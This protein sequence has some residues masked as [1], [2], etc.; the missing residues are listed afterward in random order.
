MYNNVI[1]DF[2]GTLVDIKTSEED[3]V[4][5]QKLSYYMA[6]QGA[7]YEPSAL[8]SS[9]EKI[10]DKHLA[11]YSGDSPELDINDVF[12]RLYM[13]KGL[14]M[15]PKQVKNTA[16]FFRAL[17]TD[18]IKVYEDVEKVLTSL[19]AKKVK[20][21]LLSNA[22]RVY[23]KAE[24]KMLNLD[25]YFDGIYISSDHHRAKPA[26]E[27]FKTLMDKEGL[28]KSETIMVGNEYSTDIKGANKIGIDSLFML[29][30][31]SDRKSKKERATFSIMDG[32]HKKIINL[33][34]KS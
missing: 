11:R 4:V 14:K 20:L 19:K 2:Y 23:L 1:F 6:Y 30:E 33:L 18:Y 34:T 9:Y 7:S 25:K 15:K 12:Y 27:L 28:K 3:K 17:T 31:T 24:L 32:D 16:L 21:Y 13:D 22:Q 5:W 29:T 10:Y 26:K 8:K